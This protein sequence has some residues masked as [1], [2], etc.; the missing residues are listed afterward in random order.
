MYYCGG[1]VECAWVY[2]SRIMLSLDGSDV[3]IVGLSPRGGTIAPGLTVCPGAK[4][5]DCA[6]AAGTGGSGYSVACPSWVRGRDAIVP[7]LL[8]LKCCEVSESGVYD[9]AV[10]NDFLVP[11]LSVGCPDPTSAMV[12]ALSLR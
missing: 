3:L 10:S 4:L 9:A 1:P 5:I 11:K 2:R 12:N 6:G 8:E 7:I